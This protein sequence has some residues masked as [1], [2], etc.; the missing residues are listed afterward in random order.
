MKK[1]MM[2]LSILLMIATANASSVLQEGF[3]ECE[4]SF[5]NVETEIPNWV[6]KYVVKPIT[7]RNLV[8]V[9]ATSYYDSNLGEVVEGLKVN[10]RGGAGILTDV[11]ITEVQGT[12][13]IWE[14]QKNY[15]RN[16]T[17]LEGTL[18]DCTKK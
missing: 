8:I 3:F 4:V 10:I 2:L 6:D 12:N 13:Y 1:T 14:V 16:D 17:T 7:G 5:T 11:Q 9:E 18:E 15:M